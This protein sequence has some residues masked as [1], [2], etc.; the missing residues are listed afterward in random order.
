MQ[1]QQSLWERPFHVRES[2]TWNRKVQHIPHGG[3]SCAGV[4]TSRLQLCMGALKEERRAQKCWVRSTAIEEAF[5]IANV[6]VDFIATLNQNTTNMIAISCTWRHISATVGQGY[7]SISSKPRVF[8]NDQQGT[9]LDDGKGSRIKGVFHTVDSTNCK[10]VNRQVQ[11]RGIH[12]CCHKP[13]DLH[14]ITDTYAHS[15][16][17]DTAIQ[18]LPDLKRN[19]S[20]KR[21]SVPVARPWTCLLGRV[22]WWGMLP[23]RFVDIQGHATLEQPRCL[24]QRIVPKHWQPSMRAADLDQTETT[25]KVNVCSVYRSSLMWTQL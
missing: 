21:Q 24:P 11:G 17:D 20:M 15:W 19:R 2:Q 14:H 1:V 23:V 25:W 9:L 16:G 8:V 10:R 4:E 7:T 18:S 12:N 22:H 13:S 3:G 6:S 5:S